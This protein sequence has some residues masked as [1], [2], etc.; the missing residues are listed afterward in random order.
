MRVR[1]ESEAVSKA[2]RGQ[3]KQSITDNNKYDYGAL[4]ICHSNMYIKLHYKLRLSKLDLL[5]SI[6]YD[7]GALYIRHSNMYIKLHYKL[8]L[9]KLDLLLSIH[10]AHKDKW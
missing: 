1:G 8:R 6:H 3:I 5:L 7:Y 10:V 2:L 4:Y 9:S